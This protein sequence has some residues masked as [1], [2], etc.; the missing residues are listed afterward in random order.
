MPVCSLQ[1]DLIRYGS[2]LSVFTE[3]PQVVQRNFARYF[4]GFTGQNYI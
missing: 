2:R 1:W 4:Q 3:L